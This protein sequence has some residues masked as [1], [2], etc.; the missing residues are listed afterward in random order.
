MQLGRQKCNTQ[1]TRVMSKGSGGADE[2]GENSSEAS[3]VTGTRDTERSNHVSEVSP[4]GRLPKKIIAMRVVTI[5]GFV[6]IFVVGLILR[7]YA[8]H[9]PDLP[10]SVFR[11]TTISSNPWPL[12]PQRGHV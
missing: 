2:V 5:Q 10:S 4:S 1:C 12:G 9:T 3:E 11:N 8:V 6:A 7:F